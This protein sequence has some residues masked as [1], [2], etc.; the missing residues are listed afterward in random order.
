MNGASAFVDTN[1][2]VY[3]YSDVDHFKQERAFWAL[4]QFDCQI[5]TQ[6]I[7]EF[8]HVCIRKWKAHKE[9]ILRAIKRICSYCDLVY[10][11]EDTI[12]KALSINEKYKYS[13]YDSLIIA[14]A[15]EHDC[16]Y[17]LTEDMADGQVIEGRLTIKN[18]FA[19][20]YHS[21]N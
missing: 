7:S 1:V 10:V 2:L 14:S 15:L 12:E 5:S 20:D 13:Y 11:Y 17:L 18:I 19:N 21:T 16:Q 4:K 3:L 9:N 8:N 6:V